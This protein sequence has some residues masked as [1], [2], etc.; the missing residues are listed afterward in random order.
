MIVVAEGVALFR[1]GIA[2]ALMQDTRFTVL[3]ARDLDGLHR[4]HAADAAPTW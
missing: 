3:E 2:A 4:W 1:W